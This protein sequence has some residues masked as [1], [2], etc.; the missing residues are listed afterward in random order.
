MKTLQ[1]DKIKNHFEHI[2]E[3]VIKGKSKLGERQEELYSLA[4]IGMKRLV[5]ILCDLG[6]KINYLELG[7]Y[8]GATLISA[9]WKND[10]NAYAIDHFR[11]DAT[12]PTRYLED[13]HPNVKTALD[14]TI[15]TYK[16]AWNGENP[17]KIIDSDLHDVNLSEID[18][19]ID[20]IFH[21]ADKKENNINDFLK[22]YKT[23]IDKYF[24]IAFTKVQDIG[25]KNKIENDLKELNYTIL[26][27][28][29]IPDTDVGLDGRSTVGLYYVENKTP[30]TI[31]SSK[32][33]VNNA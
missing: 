17:I 4:G 24:I 25:I 1:K 26:V 29:L 28:K 6:Y 8:R 18:K 15:D 23:V 30:V 20:V 5:N 31:P 22:K 3:M 33:V 11:W 2:A 21:D 14:N 27:E 13:G 16:R 10:V 32:K 19:K 9:L 12:A 7:P